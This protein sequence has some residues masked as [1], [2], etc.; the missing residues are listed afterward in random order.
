MGLF[1]FIKGLFAAG[2]SG[3]TVD[4][5]NGPAHPAA[6]DGI[7]YKS[8]KE[9][10]M[11][12]RVTTED[13]KQLTSLP[14]EWN[15]EVRKFIEPHGHPFAYIDL[16]GR[17]V[18]IAKKELESVNFHIR[19]ACQLCP[20]LPPRLCIPV[21][22]ILFSPTNDRGYTRLKCTPHTFT[23]QPSLYPASL[24]FMTDLSS[25]VATTHGELFYGQ[26]GRINK[27]V[28]YFWR[29]GLGY[30]LYYATVSDELT[31]EKIEYTGILD[32]NMRPSPIYKAP[33]ILAAEAQRALN[34]SDYQWL[35]ENIP[36]KCPKSFSGYCRMKS[37]NTKNY[38]ILKQLASEHGRQ[39]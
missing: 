17:N 20:Q 29:K 13:M 2:S 12:E 25:D 34:H 5:P 14:Y 6:P 15:C 24:L 23:G 8:D 16:L 33:H 18:D 35:Q 22:K 26:D 28:I 39:I 30:F 11:V 36:D 31:L 27:A 38:Q 4:L 1:D 3:S 19:T 37:Q 7:L 21:N 32:T 9:R 10:I